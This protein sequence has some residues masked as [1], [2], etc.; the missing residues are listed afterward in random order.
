MMARYTENKKDYANF[1]KTFIKNI[2]F[3]VIILERI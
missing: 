3:V 1:L 2:F